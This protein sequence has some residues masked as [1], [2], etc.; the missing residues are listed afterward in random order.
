MVQAAEQIRRRR[1]SSEELTGLCLKR[2]AARD[3]RL[4][5]YITVLSEAALD[6]ARLLDRELRQGRLR[7]PLHG[8]PVAL[9]DNI[10]TAGIRTT[11]ASR[12]FEDR[13]P[14]EDAEVARRV[15]QAGA[16]LLGKLNL[17]EMAFEGT[18]TTGC[19]GPVHNP[20]DLSRITGGSSAGSA[21]ALADGLCFASVGSDDGGSVRIPGAYCGVVGFKPSYG[22]V[23]TRG[24]VPS[25]YSLDCAGPMTRSVEDAALL[26][27]VVAGYDPRDA[28][29]L[30]M[31]VPPYTRAP[32]SSIAGLRVGVPRPYFFDRLHDD[33]A[34]RVEDAI[35]LMRGKTREVRDVTLPQFQ[36]VQGGS[37]DIELYHYQKEFFEKTPE[38]YHP[39]SRRQLEAARA[40]S[41]ERYVE[42]LK[43]I[44][45]ARRDIRQVF[46][47]VDVLLLPTMREP[48]PD[49]EGIVNQ[50]H[51]RLP[52]NVSAFNRFGL[53]ALTLPCGFSRTGLPVGLQVVG[54][55][56][57]ES[58][59]LA[60]AFAYQQ[61][62]EWHRRHPA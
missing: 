9:K 46:R 28:V 3:K 26:L 41:A 2:I 35:R 56:F 51:R 13:V 34:A 6:R 14:A 31:P 49:I 1:I 47:E 48:A 12:I 45:E 15:L 55:S 60:V 30:D 27:G 18:G 38:K 62:T 43:R 10:D 40:I 8:V 36:F 57:G 61:A 42:T 32:G 39:W 5:A 25:A 54:P 11:A 33:V 53:P 24:I 21:A 20:W 37:T 22:R 50:T 4:N 29:T 44:R 19:F 52:S 59:V 7:G 17:D 23:S 58:V 16:V